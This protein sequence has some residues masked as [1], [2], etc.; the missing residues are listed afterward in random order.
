MSNKTK[1]NICDEIKISITT[2]NN[3][4]KTGIIPAPDVNGEYSD[5]HYNAIISRIKNTSK[6]LSRRANRSLAEDKFICYLGISDKCRKNLLIKL[7]D[8]FKKSELT[9]SEGVLALAI[10][11]LKSNSL[12]GEEWELLPQTRIERMLCDWTASAIHN[13]DKIKKLFSAFAV[14]NKDDDIIGAFYQSIQSIAQKSSLGSYYTPAELLK[15]ISVLDTDKLV[16]DP[17]CGSGGILLRIL[18]RKHNSSKIYARDI[19]TIALRICAVNLALFFHDANFKS[20]IEKQD[21]LERKGDNLFALK[22]SI[23]FDYIVTNPPWGSKLSKAE[24]DFLIKA[25]PELSTPETF[26]IALN[27]AIDALTETGELYFFLPYSLLNVAAHKNMR[28]KLLSLDGAMSI[29]VLGSA[30]SKVL[31][32]TV[33]FHLNKAELKDNISVNI[34]GSSYN[35]KKS[36]VVGPNFIFPSKSSTTDD[37][38][39]EK[40]YGLH[41][42][43]LKINT[44]FA[45][46]IVTGNNTKHVN[47]YSDFGMEPIF[48]G[49][50][51]LPYRYTKPACYINFQPEA[52]QQVAQID[53][54]RQQKIVYRFICNKIICALDAE[55]SLILNSANLFIPNHYPVKSIVCLFNSPVYTYLYRKK[56]NSKKVLKSH[57][58]DF[59]L[60]LIKEEVHQKMECIHDLMREGESDGDEL[61]RI[62]CGIFSISEDELAYIIKEAK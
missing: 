8:T 45:L 29:Q 21:I 59:P 16:L 50:D 35:L 41:H 31:S 11:V 52:Y 53:Y 44:I 37:T 9:I 1:N 43:T 24:K 10:T 2:V 38:I 47:D 6:K 49:K 60:P 12:I 20:V 5:D 26:S 33:L 54:Y 22:S 61:N 17:C 19:D 18:D 14:E 15:N 57:L 40:I 7:V 58:Q 55:N 34:N 48:R 4:I 51:I 46:G 3:W 62:I 36:N 23:K 56:F 30:F 32:E 25:Y 42:T 28:K 27:N 13:I 39:I